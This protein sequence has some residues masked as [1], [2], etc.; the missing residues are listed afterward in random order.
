[1]VEP[2]IPECFRLL[3]LHRGA[4]F[5]AVKQAY[6][7]NLNKCHPDRFQ[8]RPDLLPVAEQKTKRLIQVYGILERWYEENGGADRASPGGDGSPGPVPPHEESPFAETP[9]PNA[10]RVRVGLAAA[11]AAAVAL[12]VYQWQFGS[13][14]AQ[15]DRPPAAADVGIPASAPTVVTPAPGNQRQLPQTPLAKPQSVSATAVLDA[16]IAERDR[17]KSA[18]IAAFMRDREVERDAAQGGLA[19]A[20]TQYEGYIRDNAAGIK[21]ALD[22][23]TQQ[24]ERARRESAAA[25]EAFARQAPVEL[26]AMRHD[27]DGWLSGQGKQAVALVQ[28]IRRRENSDIGIFSDTEDP[29]KIFEF[30]TAEEAGGPEVNIAAK[31]GVAVLQPDAR[32]FPHFRSNIFLYNPEGQVLVRMMSSI[33]E[34]HDALMNEIGDKEAATEAALANWDAVHPMKPAQLS[35]PLQSVMD[36]RDRAADRL[37]KAQA[38]SDGAALS[39]SL[40]RANRAFAQ[41]AD[42]VKWAA[43]IAAAQASLELAKGGH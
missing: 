25:R 42:G 11:A 8:K 20:Q 10:P 29:R 24:A 28:E 30:W 16:M 31:T 5:S 17:V 23:T 41:S 39:T 7:T 26:E 34:R 6:R 32:F 2:S 15:T 9:S 33:A 38:R 22:E 43:R 21:E 3:K 19:A 37:A 4:D 1:M 35:G 27:F 36:G 12:G 40:P 18:W 13:A 14:P